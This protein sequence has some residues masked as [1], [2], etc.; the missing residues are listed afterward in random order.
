MRRRWDGFASDHRYRPFADQVREGSGPDERDVYLKTVAVA[1]FTLALACA[2]GAVLI[3]Y[4]VHLVVGDATGRVVG[5]GLLACAFSCLGGYV[6]ALWRKYRHVPRA[7]RMRAFGDDSEQYAAA[8]R[9]TLPRNTSLIGQ[10]AIGVF[11]L[12]AAL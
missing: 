9:R 5:V 1:W 10:A 7:R 11:A 12:V 3:G 8:L 4:L 6:N 2:V